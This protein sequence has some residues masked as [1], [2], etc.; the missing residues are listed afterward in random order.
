[1]A[2]NRVL[3]AFTAAILA[4]ALAAP[5]DAQLRGREDIVKLGYVGIQF[6]DAS[7]SL[8]G[9]NPADIGVDVK[10]TGTLG[11]TYTRM[12]TDNVGVEGVFGLPLEVAINGTGFAQPFGEVVTTKALP[13]VGNL[14]YYFGDIDNRF[15]PY[16][17][18]SGVYAVFYDTGPSDRLNREL[19]GNT[20]IK[21]RNAAGL[22]AQAGVN[23]RIGDGP[24]LVSAQVSYLSLETDADL[25][26]DTVLPIFGGI[27]IGNFD[28]S[29]NLKLDPVVGIVSIGREF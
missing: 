24:Y 18:V 6:Q 2:P 23:A 19:F 16:V 27:P 21:V 25:R 7:G 3:L 13:L 4:G 14:N 28:R 5:A 26:T 17:G 11:G 20:E 29:I 8:Q 22:G 15:R 1:M 10:N 9:L 12:I